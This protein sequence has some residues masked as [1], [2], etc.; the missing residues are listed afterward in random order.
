MDYLMSEPTMNEWIREWLPKNAGR[1]VMV[2][3]PK[4]GEKSLGVVQCAK[5][6]FARGQVMV[7]LLNMEGQFRGG[8]I[9]TKENQATTKM[10]RIASIPEIEKR[11]LSEVCSSLFAKYRRMI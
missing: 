1:F 3:L 6:D 4:S 8:F 9:L 10:L 7:R 5:S 11:V 2:E